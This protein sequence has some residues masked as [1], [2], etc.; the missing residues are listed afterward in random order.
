[1]ESCLFKI[2][3]REVE[4]QNLE[5]HKIY[6]FFSKY[7]TILLS[8]HVP[9]SKFT[10]TLTGTH[11]LAR[12]RAHTH[13]HTRQWHIIGHRFCLQCAFSPSLSQSG[14]AQLLVWFSSSTLNSVSLF[15]FFPSSSHFLSIILFLLLLLLLPF[16]FS[17]P[18]P[19][20]SIPPSSSS[21]SPSLS[22]SSSSPAPAR[23]RLL[24]LSF[25]PS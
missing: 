2:T 12:E 4:A 1:M 6:I 17:S 25:F 14:L 7:K 16:L 19:F 21:S 22:P 3:K 8:I 13:I 9:T 23:L 5:I 11:T 24:L 10:F 18:S 15:L 20:L